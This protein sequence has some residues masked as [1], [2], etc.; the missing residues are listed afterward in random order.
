VTTEPIAARGGGPPHRALPS[1][2]VHPLEWACGLLMA[3][4]TTIVFAQVISRYVLAYP[5]EWPEEFARILFVWLALLGAVL[6]FRKGGHFSIEAFVGLLPPALRRG[7]A[8]LLRVGL[9]GFLLLVTFL[10]LDATLRVRD[11]LTTATEISMSYGYA[12]VP[13]SFA[14]M[15]AEMARALWRDLRGARK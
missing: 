3:A 6:A 8:V 12:A 9:L 13:V 1:L 10:G 5:W 7:A 4:L 14:L 15:A 2:L 11:Q